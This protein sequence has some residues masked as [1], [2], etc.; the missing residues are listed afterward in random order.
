M[1]NHLINPI[2]S[3]IVGSLRK[4]PQGGVMVLA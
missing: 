1:N 2:Y 4:F 3:E